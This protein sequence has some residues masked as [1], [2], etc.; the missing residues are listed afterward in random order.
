MF[1]L[2]NWSHALWFFFSA[3]VGRTGVFITLSCV[4]ERMQYEGV[5]DVFQTG[6]HLLCHFMQKC[7]LSD[8]EMISFQRGIWGL[9]AQPWFRQRTNTNS[10]TGRR[11]NTSL[12][13]IRFILGLNDRGPSWNLVRRCQTAKK[14]V[15]KEELNKKLIAILWIVSFSRSVKTFCHP[16]SFYQASTTIRLIQI[17]GGLYPLKT[18]KIIKD[19]MLSLIAKDKL[20]VD[21]RLDLQKTFFRSFKKDRQLRAWS[22][23]PQYIPDHRQLWREIRIIHHL[24]FPSMVPINTHPSKAQWREQRSTQY[25]SKLCP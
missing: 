22:T 7:I 2:C 10:V 9:N 8:I 12:H 24:L 21:L 17:R 15:F 14:V 18:I 25:G 20:L 1:K 16:A 5:V 6:T 13:L 23:Y 4:L 3:G 19:E 11:S